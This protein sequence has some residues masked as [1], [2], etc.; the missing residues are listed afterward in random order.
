MSN[1]VRGR[2]VK[3]V[4]LLAWSALFVFLAV[5]STLRDLLLE[6]CETRPVL[7]PVLLVLV[8]LVLSALVLPCSPVTVL[9][10]LLWSFGWGL[11]YSTIAT[12]VAS[13]GTF[14]I[15]RNFVAVKFAGLYESRM[16]EK[17]HELINRHSWRASMLA[18]V[19]PV[20]PGSSLG[21]LFGA[22]AIGV[23]PYMRG[24]IL[25]TLPLQLINVGL[26]HSFGASLGGFNLQVVLVFLLI[27]VAFLLYRFL[28]PHFLD[29][30]D[31][32]T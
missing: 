18:H 20:L 12:L 21:Y 19:N 15:A 28:M 17:I 9:A 23:G 8:Q 27:L 7:A 2:I 29:K 1:A 16:L 3:A 5:N 25:G 30:D 24:A 11:L 4:F 6:F 10:G 13:L 22:S 14:L 26:G 32:S 31:Q